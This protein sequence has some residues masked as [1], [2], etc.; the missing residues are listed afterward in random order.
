MKIKIND[1]IIPVI[2]LR[3]SH[4]LIVFKSPVNNIVHQLPNIF[5]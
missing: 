5:Q 2:D 1:I 3:L 4:Y